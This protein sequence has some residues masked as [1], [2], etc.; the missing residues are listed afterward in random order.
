MYGLTPCGLPSAAPT[1][2]SPSTSI[3]S[4]TSQS[5]GIGLRKGCVFFGSGGR[6]SPS[7]VVETALLD[8]INTG[9]TSGAP[10]VVPPAW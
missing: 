3:A 2:Q 10:P 7:V 4:Q 8:E 5:Q 6:S 1:H 9:G